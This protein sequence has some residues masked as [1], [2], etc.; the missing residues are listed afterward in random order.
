MKVIFEFVGGFKDGQTC[1]GDT[2]HGPSYT[3]DEPKAF[4][5]IGFFEMSDHG[6]IGARFMGLSDHSVSLIQSIG[7]D[8]MKSG[9]FKPQ[10]H[11]YEVFD[12]RE[13]DNEVLIRAK[14]VPAEADPTT[15]GSAT[16]VTELNEEQSAPNQGQ[17][18]SAGTV[19]RPPSFQIGD[20]KTLPLYVLL[21]VTQEE[22]PR[23][24]SGKVAIH[25]VD[26][27]YPS[28]PYE[29]S[30]EWLD[31]ISKDAARASKIV[32]EW[33]AHFHQYLYFLQFKD[34]GDRKRIR[35]L[36]AH[37]ELV[38]TLCD[39]RL[40]IDTSALWARFDEI[41]S[42]ELIHGEYR[43]DKERDS[44]YAEYAHRLD[45]AWKRVS[46]RAFESMRVTERIVRQIELK[47]AQWP[48]MTPLYSPPTAA[49]T[50]GIT[51]LKLFYSYSHKDEELRDQLETHLA[52]LKRQGV[53]AEWHD[54]RITGGTAWKGQIDA[55][56]E[57]ADVIL[58]VVSADFIASDYCY[59]KEM[60]R[61][62]ERHKAGTVRIIPVIVR[63]CDWDGTP[64]R[65]LLAFPKDG[66]AITS[67]SNRDEAFT[68]VAKGIRKAVADINDQRRA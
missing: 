33:N 41:R 59:D 2:D 3:A 19:R 47:A 20:F 39:A 22:I 43:A 12:R 9:A 60:K 55:H 68:D 30:A 54:R 7:A 45:E 48:A 32:Q 26:P 62:M 50:T 44:K 46:A 29:P 58:L 35:S 37:T 16:T 15:A 31:R 11:V 1:I 25:Y 42:F 21:G 51:P 67:W 66:K 23:L 27:E 24:G 28:Y 64:F 61:A 13:G 49:V 18:G 52:G 65:E 36:S 17:S 40:G 8:A 53:I 6:R 34:D 57:S 63:A 4:E 38:S 5:A 56:L 14:Y 10:K